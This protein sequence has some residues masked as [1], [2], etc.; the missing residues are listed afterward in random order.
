MKS[1]KLD[2]TIS[3][4]TVTFDDDTTKEYTDANSYLADWPDREADV[5]AMNWMEE[6]HV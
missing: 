1:V 3:T 5:I 2:W 4:I 6:K